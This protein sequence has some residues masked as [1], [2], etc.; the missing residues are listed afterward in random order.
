MSG[1]LHGKTALITGAASGIGRASALLFAAEGARIVVCDINA[2]GGEDAA[3]AIRESGGAAEFV[4]ADVTHEQDVARAFAAA[5]GH[6]GPPDVLHNC[7]GGFDR[8]RRGRA[9]AQR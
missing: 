3:Q 8:R 1:R 4:Y 7:A 5:V 9:R 2:D 6:Y